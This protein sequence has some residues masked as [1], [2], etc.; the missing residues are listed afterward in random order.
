MLKVKERKN[1]NNL[2]RLVKKNIKKYL[3]YPPEL[4]LEEGEWQ[5]FGEESSVCYGGRI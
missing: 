3:F 5:K 4:R 2:Y 1:I